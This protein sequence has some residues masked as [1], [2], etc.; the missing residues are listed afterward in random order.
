[1]GHYEQLAIDS[2]TERFTQE[3]SDR[4]VAR[5]QAYF[6]TAESVLLTY[7]RKLIYQHD[8]VHGDIM[9]YN[10]H[11]RTFY[12]TVEWFP[13]WYAYLYFGSAKNKMAFWGTGERFLLLS[14]V[15]AALQPPNCSHGTLD[16]AGVAPGFMCSY[17]PYDVALRPW[18]TLAANNVTRQDRLVI[19]DP[20]PW[21]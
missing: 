11:V 6:E 7:R 1:M 8:I 19:G 20:Y 21:G 12:E 9:D 18:Y 3:L 2:I 16:D 14:D 15:P 10:L 5:T 4:V 17:E 13:A